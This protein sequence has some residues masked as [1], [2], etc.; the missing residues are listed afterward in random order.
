MA[1]TITVRLFARLAELAGT[2]EMELDIGE[3]LT[4]ADAYRLLARDKPALAGFESSLAFARNQEYVSKDTPLTPGDELALIPPVSGGGGLFR[5]TPEVLD[6]QPLV[7]RVRRDEA[8]AVVLFYGVV[9]NHNAGRPVLY[10]EY[11]AY[12]EMAEKVMGE[13]SDEIKSR[14]PVAE[15]AA[16]HRT[17]RMEIG[18]ASL[19]VAVSAAHRGEAFEACHAYVD[20]LKE[21]VP[22]WKK[23]VFEGG[24]EWIEGPGQHAG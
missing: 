1:N 18:E 24:E 4:A 14:W 23:E 5:V 2:R 8:G 11:D 19:L 10:L 3:G 9:R 6:P 13:L 21:S 16:L 20:R 17:G 22:V 12:P 15:I 7:D